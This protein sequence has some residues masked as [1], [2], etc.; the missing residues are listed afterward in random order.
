MKTLWDC[1]SRPG[2]HL[3]VRIS[4]RAWLIRAR[5]K[6]ES[7]LEVSHIP[8]E[9]VCECIV[10]GLPAAAGGRCGLG[11]LR[12]AAGLAVPPLAGGHSE[13]GHAAG[14]RR[15]DPGGPGRAVRGLSLPRGRAGDAARGEVEA[16]KGKYKRENKPVTRA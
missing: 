16:T 7:A 2:E 1:F 3:P 13:R 8:H 11:V 4:Q 5:Y 12:R 6:Q 14:K 15:R 9:K 10:C